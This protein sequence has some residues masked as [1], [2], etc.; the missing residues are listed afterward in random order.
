MRFLPG[1][2]DVFD[3]MFDDGW[4]SPSTNAMQC[5]IKEVDNNYEMNIALPGNKKEDISLGLTD[6]YLTVSANTNQNKEEKDKNGKVIRSERYTGSCSR[7]FYVGEGYKEEDFTAK[8][9]NGELMI[10]FPK[11]EPEKIEEK[12]P[13]MIEQAFEKEVRASF[14]Y[15]VRM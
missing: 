9:E 4:M 3:D 11:T 15:T 12:K 8:F 2:Y 10:T 13:I 14:F 5:D 1:F 7:K 6:G